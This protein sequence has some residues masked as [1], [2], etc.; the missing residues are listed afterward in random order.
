MPAPW[1]CE[2]SRMP[3]LPKG[4]VRP[5]EAVL[6]MAAYSPPTAGRLDKL[7]LDFNEN[8]VGCSPR[9]IGRL[10]EC[11]SA[12]PL[13]VYPEYGDAKREIAAFF[14]TPP[15]NFVFTNV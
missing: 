12:G 14:R 11:L 13:A 6:R 9:V 1:K 5:R 7:R 4:C 8:T 15:E 2:E 3:R 10:R